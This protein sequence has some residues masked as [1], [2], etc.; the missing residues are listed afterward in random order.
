MLKGVANSKKMRPCCKRGRGLG[1]RVSYSV[2]KQKNAEWI[3][4]VNSHSHSNP[5][6]NV[7]FGTG[8]HT[9]FVEPAGLAHRLRRIAL[10]LATEMRIKFGRCA[11]EHSFA[12]KK[13]KRAFVFARFECSYQI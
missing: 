11:P 4:T 3:V 6:P 5:R 8:G 1:V 7:T 10:P 2:S 13:Q 9:A 12:H